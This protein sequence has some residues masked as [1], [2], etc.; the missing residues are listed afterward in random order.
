MR[1]GINATCAENR[2]GTGRYAA[3]LAAALAEIDSENNYVV[4]TR[5]GSPLAERLAPFGHVEVDARVGAG[6]VARLWFERF[7]LA[8]WIAEKRLDVFHGP[9]FVLPPRCPAASV[10]T[11][12]DLVFDL[13]P[14]TVPKR[15]RSYYR[16]TIPRSIAMADR[17]IADSESTARDVRERY[18]LAPERVTPVHLGVEDRFFEEASVARREEVRRR[19]ELP[20]RFVLAVGTLEP[21]KNLP[22]LLEGYAALRKVESSAPPLVLA[23]RRGW[24]MRGVEDIATRLGVADA[25]RWPGFIDDADL[26]VLYG[27]ADV[28]AG[29]SLY[30]GFGLPLLEAMAAATP[31]VAADNSSMPEVVGDAGALVDARAPGAIAEA[32]ARFVRDPEEA[33]RRGQ[34]CQER[35]RQF[36]WRRCAEKTLEV[37]RSA[38]A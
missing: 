13:Y 35:A 1:I 16:R 24:G 2:S 11:I 14:E 30:E 25:V 5:R 17:V 29:V 27:L 20:D 6:L 12:H 4:L 38:G 9:A 34:A 28:F 31:V 23:G 10:V 37:Y 15:R 21:R 22:G 3:E 18:G 8:R 26:P 33:K 32:L 7:G 19:Y 36:T